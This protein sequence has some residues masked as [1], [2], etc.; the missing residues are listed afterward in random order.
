M[1]CSEKKELSESQNAKKMDGR[2]TVV[3]RFKLNELSN[4]SLR[5]EVIYKNLL[6][7]MRKFY[8]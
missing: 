6:R 8:L 7:D 2:F 5:Y 1:E 4:K 3:P